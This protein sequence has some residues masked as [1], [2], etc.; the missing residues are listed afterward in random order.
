MESSALGIFYSV[1]YVSN[2][3]SRG[4]KFKNKS[5]V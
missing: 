4:K 3:S 2:I 5:I 1:R